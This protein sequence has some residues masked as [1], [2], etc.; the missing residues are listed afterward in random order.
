M[1][2]PI[3]WI[4]NLQRIVPPLRTALPCCLLLCAAIALLTATPLFAQQQSDTGGIQLTLADENGVTV[5]HAMV[6]IIS[7]GINTHVRISGETDRKGIF[8]TGAYSIDPVPFGEYLVEVAAK[9][10]ETLDKGVLVNQVAMTGVRL[11]AIAGNENVSLSMMNDLPSTALMNALLQEALS[12]PKLGDILGLPDPPHAQQQ[13][14]DATQDT[15]FI[16]GYVADSNG[17]PIPNAQVT[18]TNIATG[19]IKTDESIVH[20]NFGFSPLPPGNYNIEVIAKGFQRLLEE[21]IKFESGQAAGVFLKL[22]PG[23]EPKSINITT[24]PLALNPKVTSEGESIAGN[25]YTQR[26]SASANGSFQNLMPGVTVVQNDGGLQATAPMPMPLPSRSSAIPSTMARPIPSSYGT[27]RARPGGCS[28]PIAAPTSPVA[29]ASPGCMART[30]A[31]PNRQ[32]AAHTG[33]TSARPPYPC[34]PPTTPSGRPKSSTPVGSTTCFSPSFPAPSPTGTI[35]ATSCTSPAQELVHWKPLANANLESDRTIDACIFRLP[36]GLW[37]LWYKNEADSSKVYFSD[38]PDLVHWTPKGIA[39]TNHGEGPVVFQWR[40]SYW[41]INDPHAG[42]AVFRSSD[43]TTWQQQPQ[44]LLRE[45]GTQPT[46]RAIGNHADVVVDGSGRAWLF[47]FTQQGGADAQGHD[48]G[49]ARRSD[50]H[51]TELHIANGIL[52][53]DRNAPANI[54]MLPPPINKKSDMAG[55]W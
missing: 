5:P 24:Q 12:H 43:L 46:D 32:M 10:F 15:G 38:S 36:S 31:S 48:A 20:G 8:W 51:V 50:L 41:L 40:G 25:F 4:N 54:N 44:N 7:L 21:N 52:T 39:T 53:V 3:S 37:R 35:H 2:H 47:Y 26:P 13:P 11:K 14:P 34:P 17:T 28:T 30:S 55:A 22:T 19:A 9:G 29:A 27:A 49:W 45:P 6:K 23:G 18:L 1:K 33:S 16:T 42:L